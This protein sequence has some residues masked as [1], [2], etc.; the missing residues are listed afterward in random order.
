MADQTDDEVLYEKETLTNED[1]VSLFN[2]SLKRALQEQSDAIVSNIASQFAKVPAKVNVS[3][4]IDKKPEQFEFKH[5]G[6]KI[7]YS[8]NQERFEKLAELQRLFELRDFEAVSSLIQKEQAEIKQRNKILKIADRH[9][10]DTVHEYLDD[11]LADD[12]DDAAKLRGAVGRASRKRSYRYKPYGGRNPGT[13]NKNDFFR[14]FGNAFDARSSDKTSTNQQEKKCFFCKQPGHFVRN[15]PLA[16]SQQ[17][18]VPGSAPAAAGS[19]T[20]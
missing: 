10:W 5:E 4:A 17:V 3:E 9:G 11:P 2:T 16:R 7:Q 12:K 8:F 19:A 13:F 15:C 18:P 20:Q 6:H 14:G 1:A